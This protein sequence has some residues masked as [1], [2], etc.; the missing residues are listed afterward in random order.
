MR[1]GIASVKNFPLLP[2][3]W[4]F[5]HDFSQR[6]W[7]AQCF[8]ELGRDGIGLEVL[9]VRDLNADGRAFEGVLHDLRV[10]RRPALDLRPRDTQVGREGGTGSG[11]ARQR[12]ERARVGLQ[13][14]K[15]YKKDLQRWSYKQFL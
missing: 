15:G 11:T 7:R 8:R 1:D 5:L 13:Q 12:Q 2:S 9:R 6:D 4:N 10:R 14:A 3:P